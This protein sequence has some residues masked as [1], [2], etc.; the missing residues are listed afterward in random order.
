[1]SDKRSS[2]VVTNGPFGDT[3][4]AYESANAVVASR[5]PAPRRLIRRV[6]VAKVMRRAP[7]QPS[8]DE[9]LR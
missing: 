5:T 7:M 8:A 4:L 9:A 3:P 1:M 6:L 2:E